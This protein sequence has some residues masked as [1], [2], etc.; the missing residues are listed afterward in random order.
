MWAYSIATVQQHQITNDSLVCTKMRN[1]WTLN[2]TFIMLNNTPSVFVQSTPFLL[3]TE[4]ITV[5]LIN[6]TYYFC[7]WAYLEY[8]PS[9]E[10]PT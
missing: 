1:D 2:N 10:L 8:R 3:Q 6:N 5:I 4:L 9:F 7:I